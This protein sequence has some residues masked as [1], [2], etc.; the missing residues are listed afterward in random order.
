MATENRD[1]DKVIIT[2]LEEIKSGIKNQKQ[3]QVDLSKIESLTDEM[4][5]SVEKTT[6]YTSRL[7]EVMEQARQPVLHERKI[8]IDIVSKEVIFLLI[9]MG[10]LISLLGS[11]LYFTT[12]P[13][14]D[15]IDNDLKYR[16]IRM[17]GEATPD[18]ILELE[19]IFDVNRDNVQIKQMRED[20][21]DYE[22]AVKERATLEVQN[23]LR[24]LEAEKLNNKAEEIKR[25]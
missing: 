13:N 21:E 12:R 4:K 9:G 7:D 24:Q 15:R 2:I 23:R 18:R 10:L 20:V 14:P 8:T 19:N 25:K 22:R 11:A 17:K 16:Y 1:N 3:P 6:I 5:S